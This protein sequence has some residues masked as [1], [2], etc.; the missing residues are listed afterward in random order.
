MRKYIE[1]YPDL[2]EKI[3]EKGLSV[4]FK[5]KCKSYTVAME[6]ILLMRATK[7]KLTHHKV[8][9]IFFATEI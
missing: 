9:N 1:P 4:N 8:E 5:I 7:W 3:Q 2:F 6:P